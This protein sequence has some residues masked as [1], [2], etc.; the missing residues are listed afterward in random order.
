MRKFVSSDQMRAIEENA[1]QAGHAP[2]ALMGNAGRAVAAAL[3]ARFGSPRKVLIFAGFGDNGGDGVVIANSLAAAEWDVVLYTVGSRSEFRSDHSKQYFAE[4]KASES[5]P[6]IRNFTETSKDEILADLEDACLV[7][8]ALLGTGLCGAP[9]GPIAEAIGYINQSKK[10]VFAVDVPS[11]FRGLDGSWDGINPKV[12]YSLHAHKIRPTDFSG[13][14]CEILDI[15][16]PAKFEEFVG[17][18]DV[19]W[20]YPRRH[21]TTHKGKNGRLLIIAGSTDYLGAPY[22]ASLGAARVG[23]DLI[24]LLV[25]TNVRAL[26]SKSLPELIFEG[27][28]ADHFSL[29]EVD[30]LCPLLDWCDAF[31]IGPGLGAHVETEFC[32]AQV[33]Q[34]WGHK[35]HAVDAEAIAAIPLMGIDNRVITPHGKELEKLVGKRTPSD[36]KDRRSHLEAVTSTKVGGTVL[37]KGPIDAIA[38]GGHCRLNATGDPSMSKGGTGDILAGMVAG[39]LSRGVSPFD[40]ACIAAHVFGKAG[41]EIAAEMGD[42]YLLTELAERIPRVVHRMQRQ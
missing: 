2:R 28:G 9:R 5:V 40:A 10:Q 41:E 12:I 42:G 16:V 27:A 3:I 29:N 18:G 14:D 7:V 37:L 32:A 17:A 1:Y 33:L 15:G 13:V 24:K 36:P 38:E 11:G 21:P 34:R 26:V 30:D 23:V 35:P 39:L 19:K 6:T 31:L 4:L 8:D 25:P 22:L 20:L